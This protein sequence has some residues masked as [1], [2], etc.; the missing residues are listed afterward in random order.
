MSE[1][2]VRENRMHGA[3]RRALETEQLRTAICGSRVGVQWNA[4]TMT[5][6]GPSRPISCHRA[7]ARPYPRWTTKPHADVLAL[8]PGSSPSSSGLGAGVRNGRPLS[9]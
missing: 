6:S 4:T 2:R 1:R 8:Q 5:W 3:M 7:S 9:S